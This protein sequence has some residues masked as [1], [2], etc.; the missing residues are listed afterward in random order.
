MASEIKYRTLFDEVNDAVFLVKD[1]RF[2]D[3]NT[4]A[5]KMYGCSRD[6]IIGKHPYEFSPT[7]QTDGRYS[8]EKALEKMETTLNGIPQVFEWK[9][10]KFDGTP[11]D[12]EI[13]LKALTIN[14]D[15]FIQ[16]IVRDV[17]GRKLAEDALR[18]SEEKYRL[19]FS[20][21]SDVIYS[22]DSDLKISN[23]SPTVERILGHKVEDL[24]NRPF[25]DLNLV[26]PESLEKAALMLD[27]SSPV[28]R[29]SHQ[30]MNTLRRMEREDSARSAV[31][32]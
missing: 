19:I 2:L 15:I 25:Q 14:G 24:I 20:T 22:L 26:T 7:L 21:T 13:S 6:E 29:S 16:G 31:R 5:L 28:S 23:L 18:E 10:I 17:S 1:Y 9:H 4:S 8:K 12:A 3:C 32:P 27:E 11:F 30:F